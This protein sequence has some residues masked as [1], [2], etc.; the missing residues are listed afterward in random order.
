MSSPKK[1]DWDKLVKIVKYLKGKPWYA[2]MLRPQKEVHC[3]NGYGDS[4]FAGEKDTSKSCSG[5]M[6]CLGDNVVKT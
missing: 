6:I 1:S 5:G 4:A 3:I 2:I